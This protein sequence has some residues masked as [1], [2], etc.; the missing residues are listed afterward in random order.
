MCFWSIPN[1]CKLLI[2]IQKSKVNTKLNCVDFFSD[3]NA[4][5]SINDLDNVTWK[6]EYTSKWL[7]SL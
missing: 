3:D 1:I 7:K 5:D 6:L 4:E 2:V